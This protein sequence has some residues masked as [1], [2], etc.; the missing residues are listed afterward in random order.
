[1]GSSC[2]AAA[3]STSSPAESD[4]PELLR[5]I[6]VVDIDNGT[7]KYVLLT[8]YTPSGRQLCLVRGYSDCPYHGDVAARAEEEPTLRAAGCYGTSAQGGG[9]MVHDP[10]AKTLKVFGYSQAF[11]QADHAK[12]VKLCRQHLGLDYRIDYGK[13]GY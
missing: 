3:G 6:P 13:D 8:T 10:A 11:G 2:S 12:T 1:M 9:R 7:F 5:K 4:D